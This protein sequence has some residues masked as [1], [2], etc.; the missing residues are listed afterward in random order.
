MSIYDRLKANDSALAD[1]VAGT[2]H[3]FTLTPTRVTLAKHLFPAIRAH[4]TGRCL[5]AGA[6]RAAYSEPFDLGVP[7]RLPGRTPD[8]CA[9]G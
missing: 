8:P 2:K 1:R 6:G 5:D 4:I 7:E 3:Y 9:D